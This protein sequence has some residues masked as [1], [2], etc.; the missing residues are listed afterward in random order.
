MAGQVQAIVTN[1]STY[2]P[3]VAAPLVRLVWRR[4]AGSA[5][6]SRSRT[7]VTA[8]LA[9]L[10]PRG[11]CPDAARARPGRGAGRCL[12]HNR[13][14]SDGRASCAAYSIMFENMRVGCFE[15]SR[16]WCLRLK[17]ENKTCDEAFKSTVVV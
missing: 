7:L 2:K 4:R 3:P 6:A 12:L 10:A 11:A 14:L 17:M 5:A 1:P 13:I 9:S 8:R 15:Q 16:A